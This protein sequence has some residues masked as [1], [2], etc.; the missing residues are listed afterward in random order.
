MEQTDKT[1]PIELPVGEALKLSCVADL[2]TSNVMTLKPNNSFAD[3]VQLMANHH[4]HHCLV[5]NDSQQ[6]VGVVSDRDVLRGL[7]RTAN[8]Q[9]KA[10][11]EIMTPDPTTVKSK[12]PISDAIAKMVAQGIHCLPVI[13]DGGFICGILTSTD[14][15]KSCQSR[16]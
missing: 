16:F 13:D 7:S 12:T 2:M 9:T 4:F 3:V 10:V 1:C 11:S 5:V 15:L 8:W 14:L 6:L